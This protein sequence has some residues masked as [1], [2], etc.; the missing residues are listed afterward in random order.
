M[1]DRDY[2][3]GEFET[4]KHAS[5]KEPY[6]NGL[7]QIKKLNYEMEDFIHYFPCFSGS[8]TISRYLSFYECYKNT[9]GLAGHIAEVGI[10]KGASL[11]FPFR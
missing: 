7:E 9:L 6:Y 11:L 3:A 8:Q 1:K 5:R 10:Y 2:V 4:Q